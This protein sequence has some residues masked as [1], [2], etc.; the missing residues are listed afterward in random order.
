VLRRRQLPR[1]HLLALRAA[2]LPGPEAG[3]AFAEWRRLVDFEATGAPTYRLLPLIYRNLGSR[4]E[5]DPVL[6]RIRGVYRRTWVVNAVQLQEGQRAIAALDEEGIPT[7]LLK[8]AAMIARWTGD[9]GVRMM[10]DFDL[11]VPR[12]RALEAVARLR[13]GGWRPAVDRSGPLRESDLA[14]EHA[15]LLRSDGGGELDLHWRA[16]MHG[17][18]PSSDEALWARAQQTHLGAISTSVPAPEDHVHH[19]CSHATTWTAA[20]RVDWIADSALIVGATG[21]TFD[22]ARVMEQA[23]PDRSELAVRSLTRALGEV[24]REPMPPRRARRQLRMHRP[25]IAERIELSLRARAP[26]ELGRTAELFL[27][28]QNHR[29]RTTDL[30]RR[31]LVASV[32]SFA[33]EY[34]RVKGIR[35]MAAQ[36]AY[37]GL[38]RP[39]WLREALVRRVRTRDVAADDLAGLDAGSLDL[40]T[41]AAVR[42]SLVSGWS[43]AESEGRWT[44]GVEATLALRTSAP[45]GDLA[46]DVTAL[47]LLHP[48]HP[49]LDVEVWANDRCVD[50]W[51]YRIEEQA[52]ASR[53]LVLPE[54]SLG[55]GEV[56]EI[57]FVFRDPCRPMELGLSE[58]PRKLGLFVRELRFSHA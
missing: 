34:W 47:P 36:A 1:D 8:G 6:G 9:S 29:R 48:E 30:L 57:G 35:G 50:T 51:A 38:G 23:R 11:L 13:E 45:A 7:M 5:T 43:F 33:R 44:D 56:L 42:R 4:L 53:R 18:G 3:D 46:I 21:P 32:P 31:P 14:E 49:G 19:A 55:H 25:A 12:D 37:A 40:R 52:P 10:A 17:A 26:H 20:G 54:E 41:E 16:L 28:V 15:I 27:A 22:W 2:L 39:P 58:D 24:L